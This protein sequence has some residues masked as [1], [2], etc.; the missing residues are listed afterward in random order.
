MVKAAWPAAAGPSSAQDRPTEKDT[1]QVLV[2]V[3]GIAE[4]EQRCLRLEGKAL[5]GAHKT[6]EVGR[7]VQITDPA[8]LHTGTFLRR[9]VSES[10]RFNHLGNEGFSQQD[11]FER[12]GSRIGDACLSGFHG[13]IFV[14]YLIL[15]LPC[16]E[17]VPRMPILHAVSMLQPLRTRYPPSI[18]VC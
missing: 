7:D 13:T 15:P 3:R 12:V 14:R 4:S 9:P 5:G 10:F 16:G 2:R 18:V 11:V 8:S 1:V 17:R 6:L